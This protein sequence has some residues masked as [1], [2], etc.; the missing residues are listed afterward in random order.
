MGGNLY[1]FLKVDFELIK[2]RHPEKVDMIMSKLKNGKSI[3]K[4]ANADDLEWGYDW[5][6]LISIS[7]ADS[8]PKKED[9]SSC[10]CGE[11]FR[12][13]NF[14]LRKLT[15]EEIDDIVKKEYIFGGIFE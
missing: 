3:H 11:I 15:D 1:M 8:F 7:S 9:L 6:Q 10:K 4:H 5:V 14:K 13:R 2:E 12:Y